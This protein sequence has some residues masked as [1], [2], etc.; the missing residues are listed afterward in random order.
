MLRVRQRSLGRPS[1]ARVGGSTGSRP[2]SPSVAKSITRSAASAR[3]PVSV[4]FVSNMVRLYGGL[5]TEGK[6]CTDPCSKGVQTAYSCGLP[7]LFPA[8][9]GSPAKLE[10]QACGL[11]WLLDVRGVAGALRSASSARPGTV[12]RYSARRS[13]GS[14]TICSS[15]PMITSSGLPLALHPLVERLFVRVVA[16]SPRASRGKS[17]RSSGLTS[18]TNSSG[19]SKPG[20]KA[21]S[22]PFLT[23]KSGL[24][25]QKRLADHRGEAE[26]SRGARGRRHRG[27]RVAVDDHDALDQLRR[28]FGERRGRPAPPSE[29]PTDHRVADAQPVQRFGDEVRLVGDR[30]AGGRAFPSRRGRA[31]RRRPRGGRVP[32][33]ASPRPTS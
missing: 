12:C 23:A 4:F 1:Q 16:R 5:R 13:A 8:A 32:A 2:Y 7:D 22:S 19:T 11:G 29:C 6:Y 24:T 15:A 14:V 21:T 18:S 10:Q 3:R 26:A 31:G 20:A 9:S 17:C 30:V 27:W 33:S 28:A 25:R